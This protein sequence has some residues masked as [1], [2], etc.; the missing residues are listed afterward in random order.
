MKDHVPCLVLLCAEE[1]SF[2]TK[3][4]GRDKFKLMNVV[5]ITED[6]N[7]LSPYGRAKWR[8]C[9]R[10]SCDCAFFAVPCTFEQKR[11]RS[12]RTPDRDESISLLG[13]L[14]RIFKLLDESH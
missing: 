7:L 5:T 4:H 2:I 1:R 6:D 9:I 13:T 11:Q 14:G 3:I 10:S 8:R 12:H